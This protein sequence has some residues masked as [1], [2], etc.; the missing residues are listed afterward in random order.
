[1]KPWAS[2]LTWRQNW[3]HLMLLSLSHSSVRRQMKR[4]SISFDHLHWLPPSSGTLDWRHQKLVGH[5]MQDDRDYNSITHW[6]KYFTR[7]RYFRINITMGVLLCYCCS[8]ETLCSMSGISHYILTTINMGN[9]LG[10]CPKNPMV[11]SLHH[12]QKYWEGPLPS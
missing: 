5:L 4:D 9:L 11:P 2:G 8:C 6:P 7:I 10:S 12:P 1:M 3:V